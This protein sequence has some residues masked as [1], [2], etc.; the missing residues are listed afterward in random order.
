MRAATTVVV[1]VAAAC[2]TLGTPGSAPDAPRPP[3]AAVRP[4][5]VAS[6]NG[7]RNDPYYWLRDD[8]RTDP[9]VLAY[10]TAE[11]QYTEAVLAPVAATAD[12]LLA[13]FRNRLEEHDATAPTFDGG[14]WYYTR[15]EPGKQQPIHCR[16][17]G[18]MSA[19]EEVL[20]DGNRL[21]EGHA[22]YAI[23]TFEVSPDGTLLAWAEDTV[24]QSSFTL[25][26]KELTTGQLR[27]DTATDIGGS[28]AWANDNRTLFYVGTD[29]VTLRTDRVFRHV[30]GTTDDALVLKEDDGQYY[31]SIAATKSRRYIRIALSATTNDEVHLIDADRPT[32][33]PVVFLPREKDHEYGL[34]HLDGRF[35]IR[36][37][38]GARNFRLVTVADGKQGDRAAWHD[39]IAPDP[40]VFIESFAVYR[41]FVA[42]TVRTGG[43]EKVEVVPDGMPAYFVG[44]DDPT[45]SMH[46]IDTP[47]PASG[48]VRYSYASMVTPASVF[49][50]DV[51]TRTRTLLKQQSIPTYDQSLYT[52]E[53]LH[54]TAPDG[55]AVPISVVYKKTTPRDGTAPLLVY[56][57]G[58]YGAPRD[59]VPSIAAI[60][61][62]DRGWVYAI[63]HVRGGGELGRPWYEA[64]KLMNK[65]N[66]FTDFIAVTEHL[67]AQGY[68][69]RDQLY[70]Q[71]GSAGG[72]LIG[73]I[74]NLRPELYRGVIAEVPF[75]DV[76]TTM[77][78]ESIPL[79][80]TEFE[81]WGNPKE[82]AA[83]EYMLSYSPYD[84]VAAQDY[85]S[86]Y[87]HTGLW[88]SRVQYYEPTKWV[89]RLRASRTDDNLLVLD[90]D[91]TSG[92]GGASGRF[93]R[94]KQDARRVA[95]L[96][97]V[98]D[99]PDCRRAW[100]R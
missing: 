89:A 36:T 9:E 88:D 40:A 21:A 25:R 47:D 80:T 16:K 76:V 42:A 26:V 32:A 10:L 87:V 3:V 33:P 74:V 46:V 59:A 27:P 45:Y 85:P 79:T 62:L 13:E 5:D 58:S 60:S 14:Y 78:D 24:G 35:C 15:F 83:Y 11:N 95:F 48:R 4:H 51:A 75:V 1:A 91:M 43:L 37:N 97:L 84:N 70:A 99:R 64:G 55:T 61:L 12:T 20:L 65:K 93:D 52:S 73:A 17:A 28:L 50:I 68:G 22:Y 31:T 30:L 44:A 39:L 82:R 81:E 38:S 49:E 63:A 41:G 34:D 69:A 98:H 53:Y 96:L 92:H 18:T 72:L 7:S 71:G 100:P 6:P 67:A 54:A 66:T 94:L 2:A 29:A 86:M 56:G 57:Y 77:L 23:G 19:P 8:E 90:T